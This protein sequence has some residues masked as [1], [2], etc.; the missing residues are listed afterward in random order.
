M[1]SIKGGYVQFVRFFNPGK[2][3]ASVL[4]ES[5]ISQL[6]P[7]AVSGEILS[8]EDQYI[9]SGGQLY[10]LLTGKDRLIVDIRTGLNNKLNKESK[11]SVH[12]CHPYD[13]CSHMIGIEAGLVITDRHGQPLDCL[14][15]T[16]T[17]VDWIGYANKE[18]YQEVSQALNDTMLQYNLLG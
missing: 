7:E 16:T 1:P 5:L 6:F 8:F 18:I 17:S 15:D 14:L 9:S 3:L 11:R 4:E 12:V 10:E 2:E 13:V